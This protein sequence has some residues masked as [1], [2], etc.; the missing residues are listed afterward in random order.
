MNNFSFNKTR[1]N[2]EILK[3]LILNENLP[4][5][6][7]FLEDNKDAVCDMIETSIYKSY[8]RNKYLK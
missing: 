2:R 1:I 7:K 4:N 6:Y 5:A 3:I 8:F